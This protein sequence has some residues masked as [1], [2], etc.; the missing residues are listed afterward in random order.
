MKKLEADSDALI[1]CLAL[2]KEVFVK[3][4][5]ILEKVEA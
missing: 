5:E 4:Q 2:G 1:S 3:Y